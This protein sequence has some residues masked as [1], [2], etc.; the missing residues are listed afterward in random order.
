[1]LAAL[2]PYRLFHRRKAL[3]SCPAM[4]RF[5]WTPLGGFDRL[6][7][8]TGCGRL[9]LSAIAM[10]ATAHVVTATVTRKEKGMQGLHPDSRPRLGAS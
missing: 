8:V 7:E 2:L 5:G 6:G 4:R 9:L 1:M 3:G 10:L